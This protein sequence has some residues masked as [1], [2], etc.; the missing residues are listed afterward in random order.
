MST[1]FDDG[2]ALL[3]AYLAESGEADLGEAPPPRLW[4]DG[5][6]VGDWTVTGFLA[7]GGNAEVYCAK[8]RRLG[9]RA[10]LKVLWRDG[11]GPRVR[12]DRETRF[13]MENRLPSFP[14]FCGAGEEE[15]RP[16]VAM[17]LLDE[18]PLPETDSAVARYLEDV[19]RAVAALHARGWLHRDLKPRN[20]LRRADGHA[21]LADFGLLKAIGEDVTAV[22]PDS[23]SVVAGREVGVGTPGY[24][25]PE[26][27]TGT[28]AT[29]AAD[30]YAL[31]ML[32]E[33]CFGGHP[34]RPW[35]RIIRRAT[36]ALPRQRYADVAAM[37]RAIRRRHWPRNAAAAILL[38]VSLAIL[39][40]LCWRP[41]PEAPEVPASPEA[42]DALPEALAA[43]ARE[44]AI[45]RASAGPAR[46]VV[47]GILQDMVLLEGAEAL[48]N[49]L[50]ESL[51]IPPGPVL[52]ARHE[53][54][55]AQ[56]L[57][58]MD[59]NPS[60]FQGPDRPVDGVTIADCLEFI[61]RL[62][63][64]PDVREAGLCFRLPTAAEWTLAAGNPLARQYEYWHRYAMAAGNPRAVNLPANPDSFFENAWFAENS[65]NE[66]HPVGQ[67]PPDERGLFDAYG[68]VAELTFAV[69]ELKN[70]A[71][72]SRHVKGLRCMGGSC[73]QG[74]DDYDAPVLLASLGC[75]LE[76]LPEEWQPVIRSTG[77]P[78]RLPES[79]PSVTLVGHAVVGLR[80]FA[81]KVP[82]EG[83]AG[84]SL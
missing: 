22:E 20:I 70:L 4:D 57:A 10:A 71:D 35:E 48:D 61:G 7:R 12:F 74:R 52:V 36:A 55:Q 13:L 47:E 65:G 53:V 72:P 76:T 66:T 31:G 56:W 27:F 75:E 64:M 73:I 58:L 21:V 15:G 46:E 9:T 14:A 5:R 6:E 41:A 44:M 84:G 69:S 26:Q 16:W 50:R 37:L 68:N 1:G 77:I 79:P 30:V 17:E 28:G 38:S 51:G 83:Q 25:A 42:P 18:C 23:P 59:A 19:G 60:Q 34:P 54:T 82:A 78:P 39:L 62:N 49:P 67:L 40:A 2:D 33:E 63:R 45:R 32:A 3:E 29:V 8:H 81:D 11:A 80:L 43:Q 24:S